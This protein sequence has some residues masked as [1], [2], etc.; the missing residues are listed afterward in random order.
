MAARQG[1]AG[2]EWV[3]EVRL[4][5]RIS[6]APTEVVMPSGDIMVKFRVVVPRTATRNTRASVDALECIAWLARVRRSVSSWVEGDIVEVSGSMKRRFY[7]QG[8]IAASRVEV[9][10]LRVS[11]VARAPAA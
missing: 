1:E 3:N 5:G 9:E 10:V 6:A 2:P 8:A 11:R 7:R 4:V